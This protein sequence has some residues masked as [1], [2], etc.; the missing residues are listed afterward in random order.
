MDIGSGLGSFF[1]TLLPIIDTIN[2]SIE[3]YLLD[4]DLRFTERLGC[5]LV[6]CGFVKREQ[7]G[8]DHYLRNNVLAIVMNR[9]I[10]DYVQQACSMQ[11]YV[12]FVVA[13][14]FADLV[15]PEDLLQMCTQ[16]SPRGVAYFP[17]TFSGETHLLPPFFGSSNH[18]GCIPSDQIVFQH[19]HKHLKNQ[20]AHF[21][22]ERL[23]D[24]FVN[25]GCTLVS[26]GS[27]DWFLDPSNPE[28]V[29]MWKSMLY[30]I[31]QSLCVA[32]FSISRAKLWLETVHKVESSNENLRVF[33]VCNQDLLFELP[34][35]LAKMETLPFQQVS[36]KKIVFQSPR[37]IIIEQIFIGATTLAE[38]EVVVQCEHSQ[39]IPFIYLNNTF[40]HFPTCFFVYNPSLFVFKR[41]GMARKA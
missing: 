17:I 16:I 28:H 21:D 32:P 31:G 36:G 37:S 13:N 1:F 9:D 34:S 2:R 18:D 30:F 35:S 8:I 15:A 12:D 20:G 19:Y 7:S 23:I 41:E 40:H 26:R 27:S 6:N 4:S 10:K 22:V 38:D 5:D 33:R 11:E 25:H 39:V 3:Y 24:T 29:Y 14:A